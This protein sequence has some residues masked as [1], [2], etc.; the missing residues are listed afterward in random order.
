[1]NNMFPG[2]PQMQLPGLPQLMPFKLPTLPP[3][4]PLG[5]GG[6][7]FGQFI[8]NLVA[9]FPGLQPP[10][11]YDSKISPLTPSAPPLLLTR[12]PPGAA[13]VEETPIPISP[14]IPAPIQF[15]DFQ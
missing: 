5:S 6:D 4:M 11:P 8:R 13:P 3:M 1:M 7:P 2:L 10:K 14:S 9:M 15:P 12:P